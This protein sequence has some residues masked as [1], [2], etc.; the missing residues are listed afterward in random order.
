MKTT[1]NTHA[2]AGR[3]SPAPQD[4][5]YRQ[6]LNIDPEQAE[7][8]AQQ[9][10]EADAE[11]QYGSDLAVLELHKQD[12]D[13]QHKK[14]LA[15]LSQINKRKNSTPQYTKRH[16]GNEEEQNAR[17]PFWQWRTVDWLTMLVILPALGVTL[18]MG[19][20]NVFANLVASGEPVFIER[21]E[22]AFF[23]SM[24]M[25]TGSIAVKFIPSLFQDYGSKRRFKLGVYGATA[26]ALFCWTIVFALNFS[27]V[28]SGI[29]WDSLGESNDKGFWLVWLQLLSEVLVA[30]TLTLAAQDIYASYAPEFERDN[31]EYITVLSEFKSYEALHSKLTQERDRIHK[32][33]AEIKADQRKAVNE[34]M[35][36]YRA[37]RARFNQ[38]TPY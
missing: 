15:H 24:L 18:V 9:Q 19:T 37:L 1:R 30:I 29:D 31:P 20:S 11:R 33:I 10:A 26:V 27:G 13:A 6:L 32:R 2:S 17:V 5:F 8:L 14:S 21:P 23:I 7:A 35:S 12:I 22:L 25:P 34:A 4:A 3:S 16:Q 28:S 38:T 36:R